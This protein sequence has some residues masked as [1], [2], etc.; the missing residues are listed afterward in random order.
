MA[1]VRKLRS[2]SLVSIADADLVARAR[3]G[4]EGAEDMLY[5][6]H[7]PR[8]LRTVVRL[9]GARQDA[10]DVVHDAFVIA[11]ESLDRLRDPASFR[12]WLMKIAVTRVRRVIRRRRLKR[13][14]GLLPSADDATLE[15]LAASTVSPDVRAELAV[16]DGILSRLPADQRIAW[17]LRKVEGHRLEDVA[18]LASCSLATAKRRIAAAQKR[19]DAVVKL[20][21]DES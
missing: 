14:L 1:A 7:A 8:A 17:M 19:I 9:L 4:H 5:R 20:T 2:E 10:E 13:A 15:Q 18:E 3:E 11:F 6:R 12:G 21:E 16:I